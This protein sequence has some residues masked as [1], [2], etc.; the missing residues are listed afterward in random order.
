MFWIIVITWILGSI[1]FYAVDG[2]FDFGVRT[3]ETEHYYSINFLPVATFF[4]PITL[5]FVIAIKLHKRMR[6]LRKFHDEKREAITKIRVAEEKQIEKI[7][8][9]LDQEASPLDRFAGLK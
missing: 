1:V 5:W 8:A 4:W 6:S 3:K 7:M 2:Y 9:E